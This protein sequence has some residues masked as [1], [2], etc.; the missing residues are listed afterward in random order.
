MSITAGGH[1]ARAAR[2]GTMLTENCLLGNSG[3]PSDKPQ[4]FF[5]DPQGSIQAIG[6][7]THGYK[8]TALC[9][10]TEVLT[11]ALSGYGRADPQSQ[12]D[13][14]ANTVFIQLDQPQ[15]FSSLQAFKR[16]TAHLRQRCENSRPAKDDEPVRLPG[17]SAWQKRKTQLQCGVAL[18]PTI[19]PTLQPWAERYGI[20]MP[21][22]LS[23]V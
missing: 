11:A 18:Y 9:L 3:K 5:T 1:V 16:E 14:E 7:L 23:A 10:M 19:L 4:D 8:G 13:D 15:A 22:P 20:A 6:G 12:N 17:S 2:E 21:K